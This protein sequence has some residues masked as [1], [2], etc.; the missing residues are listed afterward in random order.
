VTKVNT[1]IV[2]GL[3]GLIIAGIFWQARENWM[4]LSATWPNTILAFMLI[5]SLMLFVKAFVSPER[6]VLLA[7]GSPARMVVTVAALVVWALGVR[8]AGF[9]VASFVV[10]MFLW[11]YV[12]EAEAAE[13]GEASRRGPIHYLRAA[14]I[15]AVIIGLFYVTFTRVLFVPLPRGALM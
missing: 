14:I 5:F 1:D 9:A 15:T 10:F 13:A 8:Y 3:V 2:A 6:D 12:G 4:P 11:W 7:E